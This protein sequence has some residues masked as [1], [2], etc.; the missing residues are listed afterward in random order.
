MPVANLLESPIGM[1]RIETV[2]GGESLDDKAEPPN[3]DVSP[4]G[5]RVDSNTGK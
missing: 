2:R 1:Q 4:A 3:R 5:P